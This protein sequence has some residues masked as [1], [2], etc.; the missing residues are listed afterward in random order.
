MGSL[1]SKTIEALFNISSLVSAHCATCKKA[2]KSVSFGR[3][4]IRWQ[5]TQKWIFFQF[6][7]FGV[8]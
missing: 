3:G 4:F 2:N 7:T 6:H 5:E 1:A 8:K